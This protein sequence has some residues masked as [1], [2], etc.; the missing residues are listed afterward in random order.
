MAASARKAAVD[1]E[2]VMLR[3][4]DAQKLALAKREV[5]EMLERAASTIKYRARSRCRLAGQGWRPDQVVPKADRIAML[6]NPGNYPI[7]D[8][9]MRDIPELRSAKPS[10]KPA[11]SRARRGVPMAANQRRC[12]ASDRHR[13]S[14]RSSTA[15][16]GR[17]CMRMISRVCAQRPRATV[18]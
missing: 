10:T 7:A 5:E 4:R 15:W 14:L 13:S 18:C 11:T 17:V 8:L 2:T 3:A 1:V 16:I 12:D 9:V 6:V